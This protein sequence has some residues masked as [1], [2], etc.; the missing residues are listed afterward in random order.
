MSRAFAAALPADPLSWI[1]HPIVVS[2]FVPEVTARVQ[3]RGETGPPLGEPPVTVI[4]RAGNT[5][6]RVTWAP[7]FPLSQAAELRF[8]RG[9]R[10][11]IDVEVYR[12]DELVGERSCAVDVR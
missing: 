5:S 8:D 1:R 6:Q 4:L 10:H 7:A 11:P 9:G 3:L 12:G 2:R